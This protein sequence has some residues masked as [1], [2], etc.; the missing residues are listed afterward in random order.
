MKV[1][2]SKFVCAFVLFV[3]ALPAMG[4][5]KKFTIAYVPGMFDPFYTAIERGILGA[6]KKVGAEVVV[7][8]YATKWDPEIQISIVNKIAE[9]NDINCILIAPVS[10][11]ALI[12]PLKKLHEKGV[13]IITV[14]TFLG[15]GDYSKPSDY[16]FVE[17]YIGTN[18][19]DAAKKF[20][21][22]M[23]KIL[24]NR[25]KIYVNSPAPEIS[26]I[27]DRL[28]GFSEGLKGQKELSIVRT[29]FNKNN[30]QL[31]EQQTSEILKQYP[32]VN[33]VFATNSVSSDGVRL[34]LGKATLAKRPVVATWDAT[35]ANVESLKKGD[36]D[37]ILAQRPVEIGRVAVEWAHKRHKNG[38]SI[39]KKV[40][41]GVVI[42]DGAESR[43]K[44]LSE[45][46]YH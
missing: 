24:K 38:V 3:L 46:T 10:N 37:L 18:N 42:I 31:A 16:S 28:V 27:R 29:D 39:P 2:F 41:A 9:R 25:G 5:E 8:E 23:V 15:D 36:I 13:R 1:R 26:S 32:D 17:T 19:Q 33:L 40:Y 34:A 43:T 20:S 45:V 22:K 11:T 35:K 7:A 21:Q 6:A 12:A 30:A 4:A 44:D 14:D